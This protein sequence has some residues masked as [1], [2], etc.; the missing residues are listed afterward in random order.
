MK[1]FTEP[2]PR[3]IYST[4]T[5]GAGPWAGGYNYKEKQVRSSAARELTIC[6]RISVLRRRRTRANKDGAHNV[7]ALPF[8]VLTTLESLHG[9][10]S[11]VRPSCLFHR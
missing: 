5:S 1:L 10:K 9:Y 2:L 4:N 8:S 6:M 7:P 11:P 3:S